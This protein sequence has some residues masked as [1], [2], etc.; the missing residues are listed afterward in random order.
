M[1]KNYYRE[2]LTESELREHEHD[3]KSGNPAVYCGTYAKYNNGDLSGQWIDLTTFYDYD[4]FIEYCERL[5]ADEEDVELMF[6][7]Y[8]DYPYMWY[9][10]SGMNEET[11]NKIIEYSNLS[12]NEQEAVQAYLSYYGDSDIQDILER[13]Q[14]EWDNPEDFAE[15]LV[16]D[17]YDLSAL[18]DW[19]L[20][21]WAAAWQ[22][23]ET[24]GD[25]TDCDGHIFRT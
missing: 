19:L 9:C 24:S 17:C 7:D 11:F 12:N 5:H 1:A 10:E 6:Q 20:I 3:Y 23:L 18:P 14:G 2:P 8:S 15:Q 22:T 25:Y 16:T 13:Y 21:D 4:E